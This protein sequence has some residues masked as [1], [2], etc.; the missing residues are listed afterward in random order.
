MRTKRAA[1][2]AV[3]LTGSMLLTA[4]GG[5]GGGGGG[6]TS[7]DGGGTFSVFIQEPE[8]P[9]VPGNTGETEGGQVVDALWTGL[10]EYDR[11]TNQP[12]YTGVA[13]S[14]ESDDQTTWTVNLKD[15]WTFHD[16]TPV[17]AQNYVDTWNYVA[18]SE[19]A[20]QNSYF[21]STIEG[22]ED[23]QA[24]EGGSPAATEMS[25]LRVIDD[26]TFE[27]TLS[28]PYAQWPTTVGYT[29]FFPL[30]QAFFDDPE[31]FGEQ[32]VG[33]GPFRADEAFQE[34]QGITLTGAN[35]VIHADRWWN[36]AVEDQATDRVHRIGQNKTVYVYRILV[37]NT[38]E[39]R[40]DELLTEKRGIADRII[41]AATEGA[42]RWSRDELIEILR[43]F[44]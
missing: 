30:P 1:G 23:L 6:D 44:E 36:P 22:Y 43:P 35:H 2:A 3:L 10:V 20:Q 19:N 4:C 27:V 32:P 11:E 5:G 37:S 28:A 17:T 16:G 26:T 7:A 31:G 14:I 39:E 13:E 25:G 40:I 9:L 34:G 18:N 8:N 33:N 15:G 42:R 29:A 41:G 12:V 21:F 24:E 38:L